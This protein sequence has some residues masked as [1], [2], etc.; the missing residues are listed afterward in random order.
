MK[1]AAG[2]SSDGRRLG[3][4]LLHALPWLLVILLTG[5]N[6]LFASR[7]IVNDDAFITYRVA[8]N[9]ANG[10][11]PVFNPGER[12]LSVTTPGYMLLLAASS[13]FSQDF[14]A[15]AL[16][17]NGLA[18]LAV[19]ALLIDA[20]RAG[21]AQRSPC[22]ADLAA[23]VAVSLTLTNPLLSAAIGMETPLYLAA[24]LAV[25]AAYRRALQ[26]PADAAQRWL[27]A[28]AAAAAAA[29]LLRPDG[30][31][32]GLVVGAHWLISRRR[33]PWAALVLGLLL[34]LPWVLFAW[35]YYGSPLPNTLAAKISQGQPDRAAQWG[36]LLWQ[37]AR[38]WGLANPLAA[39]LAL[40]GA[41]LAG[42]PAASPRSATL[43]V[44]RLLLLWG[45]LYILIHA[46][47]RARG[48]FWYYV[49]LVPAAALLAG[50]GAAAVVG[51]LGV[52]RRD[53][54]FGRVAASLLAVVLLAALLIPTLRAAASLASQEPPGQRQVAYERT[55][56]LL[57]ELCQQPG[58]EPVGMTEIGILGYVSDCRILDFSGLLHPE[59]AQLQLPAADK[60][61][62]AIKAHAPPLVVLAG[63]EGYPGD[64]A[65]EN[66][67]RQRYEPM[68]IQDERG[69]RSIIHR[70]ALGPMFQRDLAVSW[71]SAR[72][73]EPA[74]GPVTTTLTFP[75]G[76][77]PSVVLHTFL[78]AGSELAGA[79]D[80]AATLALTGDAAA[81]RN[82]AV[83]VELAADGA[84]ALTLAGRADHQPAAAAWIE[85]NAVTS[86]HYFGY[87]EEAATQ[88][89]PSQQLNQGDTAQATLAPAAA[90][91]VVLDVAYRD[92]PGVQLAVSVDGQTLGIVGGAGDA[93]Q[94]ARFE[95]PAGS[96]P[97]RSSVAVELR[98]LAEQPVQVHSAALV[99]PSRPPYVP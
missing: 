85:S 95:L 48:Y 51:W 7:V 57:R 13:L 29:F 39:A 71:W 31:L 97:A 44:R 8:R 64:V 94:T 80:G 54:R 90:G 60:I 55:G 25:F 72:G 3:A 41:L 22:L 46:L 4:R 70:R 74:G 75:A 28:T 49:P 53:A 73:E 38:S 30:I 83:P 43:S 9:L 45:A 65:S 56:Q 87:F 32:V 19:G 17:W 93:W 33:V 82:V 42:L 10:L 99:D 35:S 15:L 52:L 96:L 5:L 14:V 18:L 12:V 34:T 59:I 11:G 91:P 37:T 24:L 1:G 6:L 62:W 84:V 27:L 63:A 47:L 40:I 68:D 36:N 16:L 86:H 81:W 88:P 20:S 89:R 98:N 2:A 77:T 67:F 76:V 92:H 66:W 50:D 23:V 21:L 69:F 26:Q 58:R 79:A 78:P 61:G